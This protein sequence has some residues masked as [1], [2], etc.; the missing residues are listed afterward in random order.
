MQQQFSRKRWWVAATQT[1]L[2]YCV[3]STVGREWFVEISTL[4]L[5]V[6]VFA[7]AHFTSP[8]C[9][10]SAHRRILVPVP[11]MPVP[12][13]QVSTPIFFHFWLLC[14]YV[15][16]SFCYNSNKML[17][18][19]WIEVIKKEIEMISQKKH[20]KAPQFK[21]IL[22]RWTWMNKNMLYIILTLVLPWF[23]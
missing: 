8:T 14:G 1:T 9:R 20:K 17:W 4:V 23:W 18:I 2:D 16:G 7:T 15:G 13:P 11:P 10:Y 22:I 19:V 21:A 6:G 5:A 12:H 3:G